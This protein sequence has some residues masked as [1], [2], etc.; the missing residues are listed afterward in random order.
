MTESTFDPA[1]TENQNPPIHIQVPSSGSV[2]FWAVGD[3]E[4]F[5]GR[6]LI[7]R[8]QLLLIAADTNRHQR[9]DQQCSVTPCV[10]SAG[11]AF[12]LENIYCCAVILPPTPHR[13]CQVLRTNR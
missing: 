12:I 5:Q 9:Q 11:Q 2:W 10:C 6:V 1:Q 13:L 3:G 7:L 8:E 4:R